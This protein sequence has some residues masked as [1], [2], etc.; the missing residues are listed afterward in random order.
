MKAHEIFAHLPRERA[1]EIFSYLL[2]NDKPFYKASIE[3]LA[4]QRK[5]RAVFILRKTPPER[6]AWMHDVL[7]KKL[8]NAISAHILQA[9]L[10]GG[11]P[12][13][14]CDFLDA[15]GIPH[16]ENGTVDKLPPPPEKETLRKAVD[17]IVE[18][19][20]QPLAAIYL[21]CF[22][23]LEDTGWTVLDEMLA[24]DERL[25]F[26]ADGAYAST[27]TEPAPQPAG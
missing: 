3:S 15:L 19:H 5:L 6:H 1:D 23:A 9:W 18:K 12:A 16:E 21:Q 24:E 10:V 22:Q 13:L 4:Q 2:A 26:P 20:G 27:P 11:H 8:S 14:L 17:V 7:S 25:R